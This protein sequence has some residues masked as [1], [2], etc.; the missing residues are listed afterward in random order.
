M[1]L[2]SAAAARGPFS[3]DVAAWAQAIGAV[4]AIA[5][6]GFLQN[7]DR[8]ARRAEAKAKEDRIL[9]DRI[10]VLGA[11]IDR[12]IEAVQFLHDKC[13][14]SPS[15]NNLRHYDDEI[16]A[17]LRA[18]ERFDPISLGDHFEIV[19]S[20]QRVVSTVQR[21][22]RIAQEMLADSGQAKKPDVGR[23]LKQ[24]SDLKSQFERHGGAS[25][26]SEEPVQDRLNPVAQMHARIRN[27]LLH[28]TSQIPP[29]GGQEGE[30][31]GT[32]N[33]A[34][35]SPVETRSRSARA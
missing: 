7:R 4:A 30:K 14:S 20:L 12:A 5:A 27:A 32:G 29:A 25:L 9:R 15:K 23:Q 16:G 26:R 31:A 35:V 33:S 22:V 19:L 28:T 21:R 18:V 3:S 34:A 8:D 10:A 6:S 11:L 2:V 17:T 1:I 24:L 13:P